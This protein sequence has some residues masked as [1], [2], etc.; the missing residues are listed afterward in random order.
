MDHQYDWSDN[1]T[2]N[3]DDTTRSASIYTSDESGTSKD[4]YL[5]INLKSYGELKL[6]QGKIKLLG[7]KFN[8]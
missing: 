6:Q 7:G 3:T 5:L 4:P 2:Y 1:S 8:F